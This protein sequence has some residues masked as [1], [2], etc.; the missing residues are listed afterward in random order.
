MQVPPALNRFTKTADKNLAETVF[1]LLLK[2]RPEDKAAK[3]AR[4]LREVL[5]SNLSSLSPAD[6]QPQY[7][8]Q[9]Y[10]VEICRK[11]L[12]PGPATNAAN[13]LP[14]NSMADCSAALNG[15]RHLWNDLLSEGNS[16]F[17]Q[18]E[19]REA[20]KEPEKKKPVV[21]KFGL[22]HVTQLV[23]MGKA[24]LVVIAHDVDPIELVVWL[25]AVCKKMNVPYIIV[26]VL[27]PSVSPP[28]CTLTSTG[29]DG[30]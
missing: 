11:W 14:S 17:S 24:S 12:M 9:R 18:A 28:K 15:H 22:N 30:H 10:A 23:E 4:L 6:N 7:M 2:Y 16:E 25:P 19:A 26:K 13:T 8:R 27:L 21:V 3:K 1:K 5:A 29:G 20:G